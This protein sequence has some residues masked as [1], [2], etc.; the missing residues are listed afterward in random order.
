VKAEPDVLLSGGD[1]DEGKQKDED[2]DCDDD[3]V[4]DLYLVVVVL[5]VL[6]L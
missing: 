3:N 5:D 6:H 1:V 4:I 2:I